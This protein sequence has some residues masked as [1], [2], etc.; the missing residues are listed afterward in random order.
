M[1]YTD[2]ERWG[3]EAEACIYPDAT[4]THVR[5]WCGHKSH[6]DHLT[7]CATLAPTL[8]DFLRQRNEVCDTCVNQM[9][10]AF[11]LPPGLRI[12]WVENHAG[13]TLADFLHEQAEVAP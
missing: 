6:T 4:G 7:A 12:E 10:R 9:A 8:A 5:A 11:N 3:D 2:T 1:Q 13:G